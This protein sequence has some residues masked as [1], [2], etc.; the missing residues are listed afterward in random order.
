MQKRISRILYFILLVVIN[1]SGYSQESDTL[2]V[3]TD[4]A[5]RDSLKIISVNMIEPQVRPEIK[6]STNEALDYLQR[7]I[8]PD[9]WKDAAD[10]LRESL[11]RLINEAEQEPF[12]STAY[13]LNT[14]PF[15]SI[16]IPWSSFY[17]PDPDTLKIAVLDSLTGEVTGVRDSI[18]FKVADTLSKA[19]SD[20]PVLP[21]TYY[22]NWY[23]SDSVRA[24]VRSLLYFLEERDSSIVN[25][26]GLGD[27]IIPVWL[28][29]RSGK[30]H[31]YW[32]KNDM[33][34]SVTVW[35]GAQSKN[36][37]GLYMEHGVN[38]RRPV[39]QNFISEVQIEKGEIDRSKL[40]EVRKII[41]KNQLWK[42]RTETSFALNQA[43]LS[44]WVKGGESSV[45]TTLDITGYANYTNDLI[46]MT[47]LNF[48]RLKYGLIATNQNGIRKNIDLLETSSKI[49][50][51]AFGK[52]DVSGIM[53]FKTQLSKGFTHTDTSKI[54][55]SKFMNPGILTLGFGL[56]YKPNKTTS[57]NFSPLS[58]K[59]TYVPDTSG[60]DQT[61]YGIAAD[62]RSKH[63]PGASFLINNEYK[64][65]KNVTITN[66]LQLFTNYIHNPLN[67]DVD[68]EM[69]VTA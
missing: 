29:S 55:V 24:A 17:N 13:F 62:K 31:R 44:N 60:I 28:N 51:K 47:S 65:H 3:K 68:W 36:T 46:K 67:I 53:L 52:F 18:V 64:P 54:A 6:L 33:N 27:E 30:M 66:R 14:Y 39:R 41:V 19:G 15:D 1:I 58:Y 25:F 38:V 22:N 10:P 42:Y 63:E 26:T 5:V 69:I 37:I 43:V 61:Q 12:D 20:R 49:N 8:N 9:L 16:N 56:D 2:V 7:C 34:D 35:I 11:R 32:L 21:F 59:G 57:I 48:A 40:L 45:S 50:H 23:Q 4:G